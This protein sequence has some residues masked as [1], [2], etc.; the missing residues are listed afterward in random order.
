MTDS[1]QISWDILWTKL[2]DIL[3]FLLL[4]SS[5]GIFLLLAALDLLRL[6][7]SGFIGSWFGC[8]LRWF[9]GSGFIGF[10]R[11]GGSFFGFLG[12]FSFGGS[13]SFAY[14]SHWLIIL[15][16]ILIIKIKI[17]QTHAYINWTSYKWHLQP[18]PYKFLSYVYVWINGFI[19]S[20]LCYHFL[21]VW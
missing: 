11:L 3:F 9:F 19:A 2:Y 13:W 8:I 6:I 20:V 15:I 4:L 10:F 5:L 14:V 18:K 17:I 1:E 12:L 7:G 16:N 21:Q